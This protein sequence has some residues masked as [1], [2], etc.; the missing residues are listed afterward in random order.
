METKKKYAYFQLPSQVEKMD[1][2]L[3]L[4]NCTSRSDL[5]RPAID[6][7]I[8]YILQTQNVDYLSPII[9]NVIKN[10]I[11]HT[12]KGMCEMLFKMA[13]EIGKLNRLNAA[14]NDYTGVDWKALNEVVN[15]EV[16]QTNGYISLQEADELMHGED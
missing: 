13:V 12:E 1:K 11:R 10:E 2:V 3:P 9:T 5:V 14:F 16:A 4:T 8:G 7:Y 6:F 15:E